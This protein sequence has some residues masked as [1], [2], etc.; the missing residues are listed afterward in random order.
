MA[1]VSSAHQQHWHLLETGITCSRGGRGAGPWADHL[2]TNWSLR[3]LPVSFRF[4]G[5]RK[6]KVC[7]H[8]KQHWLSDMFCDSR[9]QAGA[10]KGTC[11][12]SFLVLESPQVT[13][14]S[15]VG[16]LE[17]QPSPQNRQAK[18]S[19]CPGSSAPSLSRYSH[20]L[21]PAHPGHPTG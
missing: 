15:A 9:A 4:K 20:R 7:C 6:E 1:E 18:Q 19:T 2:S 17:Y 13:H 16:M 8:L 12:P 3:T 21:S 5:G 10:S 11:K 14:L